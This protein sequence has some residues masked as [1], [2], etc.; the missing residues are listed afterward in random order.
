MNRPLLV[1]ALVIAVILGAIIFAEEQ[2]VSGLAARVDALSASLASAQEDAGREREE[3]ER[4]REQLAASSGSPRER[5]TEVVDLAEA[6]PDPQSFGADPSGAPASENKPAAFMKGIAQMF[7]DPEMRKSLKAQ[8]TMGIGMMYADL[9][10]KLGLSPV[11]NEQ[12]ADILAERQMELSTAAMSSISEGKPPGEEQM[13][14]T[15]ETQ[16]RYEEQL[17]A[18]LGEKGYATLQNYEKTMGDRVMLQQYDGAFSAAGAPLAATDRESLL[19]IMEEE[20]LRMPATPFDAT[21]RNPQAQIEAL[22]SEE[23]VK[24]FVSSQ[25]EMNARVL[26]RARQTLS[27]QQVTALEKVQAQMMEMISAQ[28]KMSRAMFQP[29]K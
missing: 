4:L 11:E 13:K 8:Q 19:K 28:M 20:R 24:S 2:R 12:L 25:A 14:A 22:G 26:D 17:K 18:T 15:T 21:N 16:K 23:S 7:S 27:P 5:G 9:F 29:G 10:K 3:A 1:I 6:D